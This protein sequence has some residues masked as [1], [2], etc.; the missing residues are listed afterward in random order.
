MKL[1]NQD[2]RQLDLYSA[3][4][5]AETGG[6]NAETVGENLKQ[7]LTPDKPKT[8]VVK[9]L[10][11]LPGAFSITE[12][13]AAIARQEQADREQAARTAAEIKKMEEELPNDGEEDDDEKETPSE[14]LYGRFRGL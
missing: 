2:H 13:Q 11:E 10:S 5:Q 12:H 3:F 4:V 14:D 9:N 1:R 6:S 8:P 7:A